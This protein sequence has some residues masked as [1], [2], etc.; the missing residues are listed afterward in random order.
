ML[1]KF[2]GTRTEDQSSQIYASCILRWQLCGLSLKPRPLR[3]TFQSRCSAEVA[4]RIASVCLELQL[5]MR[6][7]DNTTTI[8][9]LV[10]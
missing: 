2:T 6:M 4:L 7:I 3:I 1:C 9:Q 5:L 10:S 8:S